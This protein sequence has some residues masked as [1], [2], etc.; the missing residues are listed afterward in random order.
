[1][2][3]SE[4]AL[5][6]V[7]E[8]LSCNRLRWVCSPGGELANRFVD[9]RLRRMRGLEVVVVLHEG[10]SLGNGWSGWNRDVFTVDLQV[11]VKG[12]TFAGNFL[13]ERL[14]LFLGP[15]DGCFIECKL[16]WSIV[17]IWHVL[18]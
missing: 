17:V 8:D 4:L 3:R 9:P 5:F 18:S 12:G 10:R 13:R 11:G 14:L 1:M 7:L 15:I 2:G 16:L 6:I